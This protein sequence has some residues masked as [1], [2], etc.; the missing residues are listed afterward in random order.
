MALAGDAAIPI[1]RAWVCCFL[2]SACEAVRDYSR[3]FEWCDRIAEFSERYGSRYMLAFCRAHYGAVHVWRG[4]WTEAEAELTAAIEAYSRARPAYVTGPCAELA[5]LRRRQGKWDE[6]ERLLEE[7]GADSSLLCRARLALDRGDAQRAIELAERSLRQ[8]PEHARLGRAP[9]LELV[10]RAR[11]ARGELVEASVRLDELK[12]VARVVGTLP[13]RAAVDLAE[14]MLAAASGDHERARCLLEDAVDRFE[15]SG[16]PFEAAGAGIELATSLIALGRAHDAARE[17]SVCVDS[18]TALGAAAAARRAR[19]VLEISSGEGGSATP[20]RDVTRRER[21][22]LRW[23]AEGLTNRQIAERL[24]V[25]EHT[26][27]RHITN[28]LRKLDLPS[29]TAAAA[30]AVRSGL[31]ERET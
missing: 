19:K 11:T 31:L 26:V 28:I 1:S 20:L 14:G 7:A 9:A 12:E 29:R 16:A 27:H 5:E 21:E 4:R 18:L 22:V 15:R 8:A 25:S 6:A 3:A 13:L 24:V 23:V 17:A 2:V 10:V 30:H